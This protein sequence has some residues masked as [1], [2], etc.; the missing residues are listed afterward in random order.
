MARG[1][2]QQLTIDRPSPCP[3]MPFGILQ[4]TQTMT[5][6]EEAQSRQPDT[7][8]LVRCA[9]GYINRCSIHLG[10]RCCGVD[11]CGIRRNPNPPQITFLYDTPVRRSPRM[12]EEKGPEIPRRFGQNQHRSQPCPH[13]CGLKLYRTYPF[14]DKRVH[15]PNRRR[16]QHLT[17]FFRKKTTHSPPCHRSSCSSSTVGALFWY[18]VAAMMCVISAGAPWSFLRP[19]RHGYGLRGCWDHV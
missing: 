15:A 3:G 9:D 1:V 5:Y 10:W 13:P 16:V 11:R 2:A 7:L 19:K 12:F 4:H 18:P 6:G 17:H 8:I 14:W